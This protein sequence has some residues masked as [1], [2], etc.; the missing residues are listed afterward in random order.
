VSFV[1]EYSHLIKL[2]KEGNI[3][4]L[5][6]V[7]EN[8]IQVA[9]EKEEAAK[10]NR[11]SN[12]VI[13]VMI[14]SISR[15]LIHKE[16]MRIDA[17]GGKVYRVSCDALYFSLPK[18]ETFLFEISECFGDWKHI[19]PGEILGIIQL[20]LNNFSVLYRTE[21]GEIKSEH[22]ASG[23]MLS[24]FLTENVLDHKL[25]S[26]M[27]DKLLGKDFSFFDSFKLGNVRMNKNMKKVCKIRRQQKVFSS[28][29][30]FRRNVIQQDTEFISRPFGY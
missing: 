16:I 7:G 4:D 24:H 21:R 6:I 11:K 23:L 5:N 1:R 20:G 27:C 2:Q 29:V 30:F 12:V 10:I 28:R 25:Y 14:T 22:K 18:E 19:Y 26:E 8:Y 17:L 9:E 13:G 3:I 15:V